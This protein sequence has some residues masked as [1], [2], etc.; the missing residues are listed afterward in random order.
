MT[1]K[2]RGRKAQRALFAAG[3]RDQ[4]SSWVQ[5]AARVKATEGVGALVA[6]RLAHGLSQQAVAD[7]WNTLF[8]SVDN[9]D[10]P[11]T[12]KQVSYWEM[13]PQSGREP[14]LTTLKRLAQIYQ[15][16]TRDLID[17]GDYRHLDEAKP[18][19]QPG[20]K[21]I[22]L[23]GDR[24]TAG[25]SED[26]MDRRQLLQSLAVLGISVSPATQ[27]LETVRS[28]VGKSFDHDD[29]DHVD[30]WDQTIAEYGYAY[31][32]TSP[33]ELMANLAADLVAVRSIRLG[34]SQDSPDYRGWCRVCG[35]LS[36]LMAK[37]L[38]NLGQPREARQWWNTAQHVTDDSGDLDL[39]LWVRGERIIHGL[40]ENRPPQVL[41]RQIA[42]ATEFA[43]GHMCMGL[44][45]TTSAHAQVLVLSGNSDSAE[46]KLHRTEDIL[47]RLP[48][49]ITGDTATVMSWGEDRLRYKQTWVYA[50]LG[51]GNKADLAAQRAIQLSAA[52]DSRSPAQ[53]KLMQGFAR[54]QS[55]DL[56]EGLRHAQAAYETLP[57][58]QRTTMVTGLARSIVDA[59]PF[60]ARGRSDVTAYREL[61]AGPPRKAIE[62]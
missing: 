4:G 52:A 7:R 10:K 48:P 18:L 30:D 59:V 23:D 38:S 3:L 21:L 33:N 49:A 57:P 11:I 29:R 14:T 62:S 34:V 31:V 56:S 32:A 13:F 8:L 50:H 61:V 42:E 47:L 5:I 12:D 37:T 20:S 22:G 60:E 17:D 58:D 25:E 26:D 35:A 44:A 43:R 39:S 40:Y 9:A 1:S 46:E 45:Q 54:V 6:F 27:A 28:K 16:A 41:L 36:G 51:D 24:E 19:A 15:C 2:P 53:I 55:G